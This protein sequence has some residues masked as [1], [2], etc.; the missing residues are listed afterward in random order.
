M[1]CK[2]MILSDEFADVLTDFLLLPEQ[3]TIEPGNFCYVSVNEVYQVIYVRRSSIELV[4]LGTVG[5]RNM[6]KVYGLMQQQAFDPVSLEVSGIIQTQRPP[7][8]LTGRGVV[9]A[10]IDT[11]IDYTNP[12]FRDADGNTRILAIWDQTIQTGTPP[13]GIP[14][15]SVYTRE[16]INRA[17]RSDNPYDIVPSRDT[18]GHGSAMAG[19]AAGSRVGGGNTYLGAAPEADIVVVKLKEC[20]P[21]L[22]EFN[23]LPEDVPAYMENDIMLG[24]KFAESFLVAFARPLVICLGVGT[25]QGDHTGTSMLSRYINSFALQ[26]SVGIVVCGGN[27]GNKEHHFSGVLRQG[28]DVSGNMNYQD[29]ELRVG[30]GETG[31]L[32]ELWGTVPDTFNILIRS[33]GGETIPRTMVNFGQNI[34]YRFVYERTRISIYSVLVEE[35]SGEE[36]IIIRFEE[37]TEGIWTVRVF[38]EGAVHNGRF[39]IWLPITQFLHSTSYFL[40]ASPYITLTEPSLAENVITAS[41]YNDANGSFY[42]ESGRGFARNNLIKPDIAAPGVNI[43][44]IRGRQTGSSLAASVAAGAVAQFMQW[45]VVEENRPFV[46]SN[47]VK[48]Y[49][50][51]GAARN[52]DVAYPNREW[53]YG[54][55]DIAGTFN[56]LAGI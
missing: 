48:N 19:V 52:R 20:K 38:A 42:I 24:V 45:A 11:G 39:N 31:F 8:S 40:E 17:L 50:I 10:F 49:L 22:R 23:M 41:T 26:R 53:G 56:N 30:A 29:A 47:E 9:M 15:G 33:P 1:D 13:A 32:M 36:L 5:Y 44:T 34:A 46:T 6:P 25:N 12:A 28:I 2:E 4:D 51:R 55:L 14:Y 37:P 21:Y 18:N 7:L 43:S 35:T 54:R 16:E 27:E 3:V